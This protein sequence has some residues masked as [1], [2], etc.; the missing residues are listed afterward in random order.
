MQDVLRLERRLDAA[1]AAVWRCWTE[2][3]LIKEWFTPRPVRT[4]IAE[5]DP[6]P[7]GRFRIAMDIP[8]QGVVDNAPGCIL[9][10][11][12]GRRLVWTNA[13]GPDFRPAVIGSGPMEF[14][15]T[16]DIRMEPD[17]T[18]CRYTA[19]VSHATAE[20]TEAHRAMGFLEGWGAATDQL[21]ELARGLG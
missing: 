12:P 2:P 18:G 17:G 5:I 14:A 13:L 3:E 6:V 20:A 11:D 9:V 16:A 4:T 21:E 8:G 19:T 1:P 15:F 10:A 7:G